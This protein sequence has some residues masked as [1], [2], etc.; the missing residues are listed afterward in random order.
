MAPPPLLIGI[1]FALVT[2]LAAWLMWHARADRAPSCLV[3]S[4]LESWAHSWSASTGSGAEPHKRRARPNRLTIEDI[5][6][7]RGRILQWLRRF[8]VPESEQADVAQRVISEAWR[9][10]ETYKPGMARLDTWLYSITHHWASNF[11]GSVWATRVD[12]QDMNRGNFAA[13]GGTPEEILERSEL[14]LRA[15]AILERIPPHLLAIWERYELD[16]EAASAIA[17]DIGIPLSTFWS[18]L[19]VARARVTREVARE[20]ALEAHALA[21]RRRG[22]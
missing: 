2:L 12:L 5:E 15:L 11:M 20:E 22:N 8:G 14:Y 16:G 9:C 18:Q 21:L 1:V 19:Q 17:I 6:A 3:A 13:A 7:S 4:P 10:R